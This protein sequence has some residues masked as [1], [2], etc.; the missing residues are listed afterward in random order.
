MNVVVCAAFVNYFYVRML[1]FHDLVLYCAIVAIFTIVF[2]LTIDVRVLGEDFTSQ[3]F[4]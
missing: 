2:D 1:V 3:E 4:L